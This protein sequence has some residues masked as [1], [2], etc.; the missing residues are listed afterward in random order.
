MQEVPVRLQPLF[1]ER[2]WGV[3]DLSPW[4]DGR[5][6]E[7]PIGEVWFTAD[8]NRTETG[9]RLGDWLKSGG[10]ARTGRGFTPHCPLLV[11]F[12]FTS[13][14]LSV[15][16]HPDDD[17]AAQHH[18]C[19]GKTEAWHVLRA[20]PEAEVALGFRERITPERA[21]TAAE[22]GE[23]EQM[24]DW[25]KV[26]EGDTILT[27][28]GTVHAIGAGL[29]ICEVQENSD[30]TYRLYDYGRP[31]ELHLDKAL[32]VSHLDRYVTDSGAT[33]LEPWREVRVQ[34]GHFCIE[35]LQIEQPVSVRSDGEFYHLLICIGGEGTISDRP[36]RAGEVWFIPATAQPFE[37][38]S[39]DAELLVAYCSTNVT[40]AISLADAQVARASTPA[41]LG[42]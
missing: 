22:T 21:R 31:R 41:V 11:K 42:S 12:L 2:V 7:Q 35:R 24:L 36:F 29:T 30:I 33:A 15:Q 4:F 23:I 20:T 37:V 13:E 17:F 26:Q 18:Q 16:V 14:R 32:A 40:K 39:N 3:Q 6:S 10:V 1:K 27:P 8:D 34:C 25:R 9:E 5:G 19:A 38:Q 28:A